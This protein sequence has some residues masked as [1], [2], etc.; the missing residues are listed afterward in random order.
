MINLK[1]EIAKANQ[2]I[3]GGDEWKSKIIAAEKYAFFKGA[4]RFLFTDGEGNINWCDFDTKWSN[5][6]SLIPLDKENRQTIELLIPFIADDANSAS[7][8]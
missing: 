8:T 3:N 6:K 5:A 4:I 2:I 1:E 7:S